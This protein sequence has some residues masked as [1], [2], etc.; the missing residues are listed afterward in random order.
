MIDTNLSLYERTRRVAKA[1]LAIH[2]G[3]T[4]KYEL[5]YNMLDLLIEC[6]EAEQP[7]QFSSRE[8]DALQSIA[9]EYLMKGIEP[10]GLVAVMAFGG[11]KDY[12][13]EIPS[14][15]KIEPIFKV[16]VFHPHNIVISLL[17]DIGV[18]EAGEYP[19][20]RDFGRLSLFDQHDT[21]RSGIIIVTNK[22][23][24]VVGST[25]PSPKSRTFRIYYPNWTKMPYIDAID[26]ISNQ[27]IENVKPIAGSVSAQWSGKYIESKKR[28][29][30]GPYFFKFDLPKEMKKREGSIDLFVSPHDFGND[31]IAERVQELTKQISFM[32]SS[33]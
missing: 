20:Y 31:D 1:L 25:I 2:S 15:F 14:P 4:K 28:V 17:D 3:V 10:I 23:V 32:M 8:I 19:V 13:Y 26:Y 18:Y 24:L 12:K 11:A 16:K 27:A 7:V 33:L 6:R 5:K 29:L 9:V 30:Y 22:R 21:L